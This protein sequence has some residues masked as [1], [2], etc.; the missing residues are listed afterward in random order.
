MNVELL[1]RIK[2]SPSYKELLEKRDKFTWGLAILMFFVYFAF[3]L[4]IA[5]APEIFAIK[6]SG[7]I[8]LGI[9]IG[10]GVI[11][12][13]FVITGIYVKKANSEF[14]KIIAQI[15]ESVRE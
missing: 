10:V 15:E 13:A 6:I 1:E 12:F 9:P 14:D 4:I 8:T 11:V 5:F 2:N 7:V 3:I